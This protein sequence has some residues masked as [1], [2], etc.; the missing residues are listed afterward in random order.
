[1]KIFEIDLLIYTNVLRRNA[2]ENP[3]SKQKTIAYPAKSAISDS[4]PSTPIKNIIFTLV[5]SNNNYLRSAKQF[6]RMI[7]ETPY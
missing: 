2:S 4:L 5:N 1:M 3:V 6:F 7:I